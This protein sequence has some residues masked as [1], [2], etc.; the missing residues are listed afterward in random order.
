MGGVG[1]FDDE[2]FELPPRAGTDA[3][4][5]FATPIVR[6]IDDFIADFAEG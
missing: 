4:K 1:H 2:R 3:F 5:D 6:V